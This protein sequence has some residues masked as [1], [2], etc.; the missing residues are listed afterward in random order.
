MST[1]STIGYETEDG[2]YVGVYCQFDG[3]PSNVFPVLKSTPHDRVVREVERALVEGGL[4]AIDFGAWETYG[5]AH[6]DRSK[7]E[8]WIHQSWPCHENEY[9][10][11]V[12]LDGTVECF[13]SEGFVILDEKK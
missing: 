8:E 2:G 6:G 13:D 4:R 1:H 7:R 5:D 9:N 12:R 10:Y 3:Y 11:R